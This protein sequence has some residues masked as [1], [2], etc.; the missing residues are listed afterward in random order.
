MTAVSLGQAIRMRS[1]QQECIE[2]LWDYFRKNGGNPVCALP[3]GTGKS[4]VIAGFIK[5]VLDQFPNQRIMVLTHVKEL[6]EQNHAKLISIWPT[7]PAGVYS[8]G[9]KRRDTLNNIIFGGVASVAKKGHLFGHVDLIII[10]ECHLVSPSDMT[11][12]RKL[13][14]LLTQVNPYLKVIGFTAT[15][16]RL[17]HGRITEGEGSVFTD[18]CFDITTVAAF[19]RLIAEGYLCPLV[20]RPTNVKLNLDGVNMRGGEFI[21][22]ELQAAV[23]IEVVTRAALNECM[24]YHGVRKKW[25]IFAS[26][27]NHAINIKDILHEFGLEGAV[28]H[29]KMTEEER[30]LHITN[31]KAGKYTFLVNNNIL[32]TGFDDPEIDMIVILRPTASSVLWVQM[33]GRGTRPHPSKTNCLV[34]DFARNGKRLGPINDP[35]IPRKPGKGGAGGAPVKECPVCGNDVHASL[36][37]CDSFLPPEFVVK[38][39]HEFEFKVKLV[40]EASE[41]EIVRGD[42]PVVE[43]FKVDNVTYMLHKKADKPD[44]VK[45][46]YFCTDANTG[47]SRMF[48]EFVCLE[49]QGRAAGAAKR[50]VAARSDVAVGT[51]QGLLNLAD[52]LRV[53]RYIKVWTNQ[54]Y[55]TILNHCFEG[56]CFGTVE[57]DDSPA[58]VA[59][60]VTGHAN[61]RLAIPTP[62]PADTEGYF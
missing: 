56:T 36:R 30:D 25:L 18:V 14:D 51:T 40:G 15:P 28:V 11:M 53:A 50:W 49:H 22:K 4:V 34:L 24:Q 45:V 9:L 62:T 39:T 41:D 37:F 27:V 21:P 44:S 23:D 46:T 42:L 2:T 61:I 54:T 47:K 20:P 8:A 6:V 16:W 32:T 48:Q 60:V 17:G 43:D 59:Q 10:D 3:T 19:N 35:L 13:I 52:T 12:Y 31:F 57:P 7:A 58:P 38:C 55:P 33:L 1:Y 26:G 5:S 29:S